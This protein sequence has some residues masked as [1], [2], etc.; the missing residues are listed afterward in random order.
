MC[1]LGSPGVGCVVY[2]Y[3]CAAIS[4]ALGVFGMMLSRSSTDKKHESRFHERFVL[5]EYS[6]LSTHDPC[7]L[8]LMLF[9]CDALLRATWM[10]LLATLT[11]SFLFLIS[12]L[13][14]SS[15]F[16]CRRSV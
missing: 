1:S 10:A 2:G 16:D 15:C 7:L 13:S 9:V 11:D 5:F 6:R 14:F 8:C 12:L 3:A 4:A